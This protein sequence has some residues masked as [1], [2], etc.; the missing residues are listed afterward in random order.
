MSEESNLVCFK[1]GKKTNGAVEMWRN[2]PIC[3]DCIIDKKS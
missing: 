3:A 1:C 2:H